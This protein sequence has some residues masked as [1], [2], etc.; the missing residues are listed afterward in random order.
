MMNRTIIKPV[1]VLGGISAI[2][3]MM[4]GFVHYST[5]KPIAAAQNAKILAAISEVAGEFDN[6]PYAEKQLITTPDK[7]QKFEMYPAR[8]DGKLNAVAIKSY[9]N[10]GFGGRIDLMTGFN[11][12]GSIKTFKIISSNETPGLGSKTDEPRFKSQ[13]NG[14]HPQK[15]ILKVRQDGGDVDA[16]TAATISSRA[17]LRAIERAFAAFHNFNSRGDD[18]K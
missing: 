17:V 11:V 5:L 18:D 9:T 13:L 2:M 16:V 1:A 12:D 14:F 7:K 3:A 15:Q 8:L 10:T 4:L 6:D